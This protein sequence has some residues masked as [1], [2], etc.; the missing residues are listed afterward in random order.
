MWYEIIYPSPNFDGATVEV[1]EWIN[2][3]ILHVTGHVITYPRTRFL[4]ATMLTNIYHHDGE[5][6]TKKLSIMYIQNC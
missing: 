5:A 6:K 2:N 4:A 1:W 3:F